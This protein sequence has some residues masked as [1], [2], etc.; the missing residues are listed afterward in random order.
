MTSNKLTKKNDK[1]IIKIKKLHF[2]KIR[3]MADKISLLDEKYD[4]CLI[5]IDDENVAIY[6]KKKLYKCI[7]KEF[8]ERNLS[9]TKNNNSTWDSMFE[10]PTEKLDNLTEGCQE[11]HWLGIP[12]AI[13]CEEEEYLKRHETQEYGTWDTFNY[14]CEMCGCGQRGCTR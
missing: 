12:V 5:G 8:S 6:N 14:S 2:S 7:C 10:S 4:S 1:M 13:I 9:R 3:E 11:G